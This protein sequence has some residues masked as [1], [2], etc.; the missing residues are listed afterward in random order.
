MSIV[1]FGITKPLEQK[2]NKIIKKQGF[3]S[4]AEF[5]RFAAINYI[6][7]FG[8]DIS[9]KAYEEAVRSFKK[10][11]RKKINLNQLPPLEEQMQDVE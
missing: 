9:Q 10:D 4:K 6:N 2:I 1:N 3:A 5:F 11:L 8:T 7:I